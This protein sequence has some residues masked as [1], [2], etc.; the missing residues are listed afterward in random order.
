MCLDVLRETF[1]A[2]LVMSL[3]YNETLTLIRAQHASM[4]YLDE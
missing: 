1:V 3:K 2:S 4:I